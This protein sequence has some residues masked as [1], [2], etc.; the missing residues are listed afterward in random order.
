M[1]PG[2]PDP[3]QTGRAARAGRA[4]CTWRVQRRW[5]PRGLA[6]ASPRRPPNRSSR[7]RRGEDR[8]RRRASLDD[9]GIA[10]LQPEPARPPPAARQGLEGETD[11]RQLGLAPQDED[12]V[13]VSEVGEPAGRGER[14]D[15]AGAPI[16]VVLP[17][18]CDF[19]EDGNREGPHLLD[20]D[21]DVRNYE[22]TLTLQAALD[23]LGERTGRQPLR[24]H[25]V[26]E[27]ERTLAVLPDPLARREGVLLKDAY[28]EDVSGRDSEVRVRAGVRRRR[29]VIDPDEGSDRR[30]ADEGEGDRDRPAGRLHRGSPSTAGG[31]EHPLRE[32]FVDLLA[33]RGG[34]PALAAP[35]RSAPDFGGG[36][37][38]ALCDPLARV[39]VTVDVDFPGHLPVGRVIA[40]EAYGPLPD[41]GAARLDQTR[42]SRIPAFS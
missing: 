31:I 39:A 23:L 35:G 17:R 3:A 15:H 20:G 1:R 18:V 5:A 14:L 30:T 28:G 40:K 41:H 36:K 21:V 38:E 37:P 7:S 22:V 9:D 4:R 24:L 25:V 13:T 32:A 19:A 10:G 34:F 33:V 29:V 2:R 8:G 6:L 26:E 27:R 16:Q 42:H 11:A 12:P